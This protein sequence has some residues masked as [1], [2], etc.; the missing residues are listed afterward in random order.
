MRSVDVLDDR[1]Q[2][3]NAAISVRSQGVESV[4]ELR[5]V[6][7]SARTEVT[8]V[9]RGRLQGTLTHFS[10]VGLPLDRFNG[11]G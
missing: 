4:E 5:R 7:P 8:Q 6:V 10:I 2:Q 1:R 11:F 9:D 3:M